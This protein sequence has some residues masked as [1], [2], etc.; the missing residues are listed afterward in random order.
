[1]TKQLRKAIM[2]RSRLENKYY[3]SKCLEDKTSFKKQ[4][5]YCNRLYKKEKRKILNNINLNEITDK[6]FWKTVKPFLSNKGDVHKQITLIDGE[7]SISKDEGVANTLSNY[8]ENAAKSLEIIE[9]KEILRSIIGIDDPIDI[10]I[11]KYETHPSILLI[12]QKV[13]LHF[14]TFSFSLTDLTD[15]ENELKSLNPKK[16]TTF[17]NIPAKNLKSTF[18]ICSP[19]RNRVW[20]ESVLKCKFPS[21]LKL[22][23]ITATHKNGD[24]TRVKNYRP[25]SVLPV[26]SKVFGRIMQKQIVSYIDEYLSPFLCGYR[27]GYSTHYALL[28]LIEKWKK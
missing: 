9:N 26:V 2:K 22:A 11:K 19:T 8:F 12:K 23:D 1:M 20:C 18:D 7:K 17:K 3:K 6:T 21:K 13:A 28:G 15:M 27:K 14:E 24:A 10:A 25:I 16:A 5:N 4:R